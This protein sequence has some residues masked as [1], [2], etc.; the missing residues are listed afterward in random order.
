[1]KESE[2]KTFAHMFKVVLGVYKIATQDVSVGS[3]IIKNQIYTTSFKLTFTDD[4]ISNGIIRYYQSIDDEAKTQA[5]VDPETKKKK[6]D[7]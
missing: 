5:S 6:P 2:I 1:M 4:D 7:S 3:F